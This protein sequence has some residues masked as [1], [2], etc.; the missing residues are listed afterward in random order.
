MTPVDWPAFLATYV[1]PSIQTI[2]GP[3]V[4]AWIALYS[5]RRNDKEKLSATIIWDWQNGFGFRDVE[6]PHIHIFNRS[7]RAVMLASVGLKRGLIFRVKGEYPLW[8]DDEPNFNFPYKIEP[9]TSWSRMLD[10]KGIMREA[11][12][13][14]WLARVLGL[15]RVPYLRFEAKTI[16]GTKVSI[17]AADATPF[18]D[19]PKWL[20]R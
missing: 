6:E 13:A 4:G 19:R 16:A 20:G 3:L 7:D 12:K 8:W 14:G 2:F 18:Q 10:R 5:L 9:G 15:L 11:E 1:G 17:D